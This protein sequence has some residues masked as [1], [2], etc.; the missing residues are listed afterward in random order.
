MSKLTFCSNCGFRLSIYR[1][2]LPK[3]GR[4]VDL[5]EP[6]E[7]SE[8]PI[9]LDLTPTDVPIYVPEEKDNKFVKKL[10][11]L[12]PVSLPIANLDLRDRRPTDQVKSSAPE[13]ILSHVKDMSNTSPANILMNPDDITGRSSESE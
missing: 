1:K 8:E 2:A 13:S 6:H 7:C 5:I 4:I 3:Y 10:N 12:S 9:E 11:E